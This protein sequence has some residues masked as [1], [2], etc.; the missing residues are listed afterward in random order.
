MAVTN[1]INTL[2]TSKGW[3]QVQNISGEHGAFIIGIKG[4]KS[5]SDVMPTDKITEVVLELGIPSG[6]ENK[7]ITLQ[8]VKLNFND[9]TSF[10]DADLNKTTAF[11]KVGP[12]PSTI[13]MRPVSFSDGYTTYKEGKA[14]IDINVLT[15]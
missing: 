11:T 13:Y 7:P 8:M 15:F 5:E 10:D 9:I 12:L 3:L 4:S 2:D 6:I 14:S 1:I